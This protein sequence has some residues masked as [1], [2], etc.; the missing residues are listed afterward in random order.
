VGGLLIADIDELAD[1]PSS[2]TGLSC[3]S[4][5]Y[6]ASGLVFEPEGAEHVARIFAYAR[7]AKRSVT[8]RAGGHGFDGQA[9]GNDLVVSTVR[10]SSIKVFPGEKRVTVG[11]GA[12]WGAILAA[13]EPHGL[14]PRVTVTTEHATAGGTL[15]GDCLSRFSPAW[16]KE[17]EAIESFTVVTAA[18]KTIK[19]TPPARGAERST[20]TDEQR[21]F[22]GVIGGLGY[23]GAVIEITY[24]RLLEAGDPDGQIAVRT[25]VHK[26][27]TFESLAEQLLPRTMRM[28]ED[29]DARDP[30]KLD[31]VW[32]ALD[33]RGAGGRSVLWFTSAF[34]RTTT[35]KR[36]L[37]HRPN[38]LLRLPVEWLMRVSW[39]SKR[40]WPVFFRLYGEGSVYHDDLEGFTFF[41]DGNA[42]AKRIGR[43]FGFAM[44]N[45]QQTFVVPLD[46]DPATAEKQ[47]VA[48][49]EHA[50]SVLDERKLTPTMNDA[51]FLPR[52]FSFALSA[53]YD[54][55]GFAVS[56]AFETSNKRT[57]ERAKEAFTE[58]ADDLWKDFGGRV[59]LVKNVFASKETLWAMYGD[60]A[61]EFF[62]LKKQ[63]DPDG[64][65]HNDFLDRTFGGPGGDQPS[66][67]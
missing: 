23:L 42:R 27:D 40:L 65:L 58:L 49:L 28:R 53:T 10:M 16:G 41:M 66:S 12:S 35:R 17:G 45:I 8:C 21:V 4:G 33:T 6:S 60:H 38:M 39:I 22:C 3:Y 47:L 37:L 1:I 43:R 15:S 61:T 13:L 9:L 26:F 62:H 34:D 64:I 50:H 7:K 59:Y 11:A 57:L 54:L 31:A 46:P 2:N 36:M 63:L 30:D 48:W 5:L 20:W 56:Y 32:C 14:V 18:G 44:R 55:P 51:L 19:A 24:H 29:A 25:E 67:A 52:D